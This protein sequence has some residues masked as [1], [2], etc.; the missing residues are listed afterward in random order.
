MVT[1]EERLEP[2]GRQAILGVDPL[3]GMAATADLLRQPDRRYA[4]ELLDAMLGDST[5]YARGD[6]VELSWRLVMPV[7][8]AWQEKS[9]SLRM[10]AAGS[11]GPDEAETLIEKDGRR[12]RRP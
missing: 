4:P 1:L 12:W 3:R 5:L 8:E 6:F 7:L 9:D 2:I 10:Y 11:W